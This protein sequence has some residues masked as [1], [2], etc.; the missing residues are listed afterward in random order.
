[1]NRILLPFL[2]LFSVSV[3][4]AQIHEFGGGIGGSNYVG[5]IGSTQFI[6]PTNVGYNL[7]YRWNKSPRHSYKVSFLQT[8][9]TGNDLKSDMP[10]RKERG[11]N[12][13][14]TVQQLSVGFEFNFFELDL[15]EENFGLTPYLYLGISGIRYSDIYFRSYEIDLGGNQQYR[16]TDLEKGRKKNSLAIPFGTGLKVRL[17]PQLILNAEVIANY[18]FT[19]NLD[20]SHPS[21]KNKEYYSFGKN[22]NDWFFY[23]GFSISYTFGKNPC[24]CAD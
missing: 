16:K 12:F 4:Q 14:N 2:L 7:F 3:M 6:N 11:L 10:S 19:D 22:V 23:T 9:L 18:T 21:S 13:N 15:H 8:K 20:G 17:T 5:N 1:M 24:Y